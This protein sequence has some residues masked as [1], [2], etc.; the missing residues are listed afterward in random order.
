MIKMGMLMKKKKKKMMMIFN[1]DF[2]DDD[3]NHE[4]ENDN[5]E[6]DKDY[7]DMTA[8]GRGSSSGRADRMIRVFPFSGALLVFSLSF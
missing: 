6:D 8:G 2:D 1:D 3:G 4:K 7:C 5:D